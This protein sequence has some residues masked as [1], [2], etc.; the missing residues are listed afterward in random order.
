MACV[1]D[2][3]GEICDYSSTFDYLFFKQEKGKPS[4]NQHKNIQEFIPEFF[5][6]NIEEDENTLYKHFKQMIMLKNYG[7]I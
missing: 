6:P 2:E 1:T 4:K 7:K 3:E 5:D